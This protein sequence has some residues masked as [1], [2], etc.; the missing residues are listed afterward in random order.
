MGYSAD[1]IAAL[2]ENGRLAEQ[3]A[4]LRGQIADLTRDNVIVHVSKP[5]G[6]VSGWI[7]AI[8]WQ[9]WVEPFHAPGQVSARWDRGARQDWQLDAALSV[10]DLLDAAKLRVLA[11]AGACRTARLA[12]VRADLATLDAAV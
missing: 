1:E 2:K 12:A 8:Y 7:G 3:V 10:P 6:S 11:E 9:V 5:V 4:G